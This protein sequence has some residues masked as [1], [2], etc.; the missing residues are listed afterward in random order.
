MSH[1]NTHRYVQ[2]VLRLSN[3][4][5]IAAERT[6]IPDFPVRARRENFE[7]INSGVFNWWKVAD[8]VAWQVSDL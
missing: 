4:F 1:S 2:S 8:Q 6:V 5:R 7:T 3:H